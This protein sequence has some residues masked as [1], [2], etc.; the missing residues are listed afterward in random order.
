MQNTYGG[1]E[2]LKMTRKKIGI[3]QKDLAEKL[4]VSAAYISLIETGAQPLSAPIAQKMQELYGTDPWWLLYGKT[5]RGEKSR[6]RQARDEL[7]FKQKDLAAKLGISAMYLGM[8]ERGD[9]PLS[10][11]VASKMQ[12]LFGISASWLL[13]GTGSMR[14]NGQE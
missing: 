8:M 13:L 10:V 4:Q 14:V 11:P 12:D 5:P 7:G 3:S 9:Q 6:L 2:R 1:G